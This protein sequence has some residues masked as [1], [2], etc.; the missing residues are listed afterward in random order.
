VKSLLYYQAELVLLRK[1]LHF[2]EFNDHRNG[3]ASQKKFA[4]DLQGLINNVRDKPKD[5]QPNQWQLIEEIRFV[6]D[7][8]NTALIQYSKVSAF[9]DADS[10][11]VL[12]VRD[13]AGKAY[14]N[15]G[16]TGSG[17][18]VWGTLCGELE[19]TTDVEKPFWKLILG[20]FLGLFKTQEDKRPKVP[21][22]FQECLIVPRLGSKPDG[23]TLWVAHSFIPLYHR[24][25][26]RHGEPTWDKL[27]ARLQKYLHPPCLPIA[28]PKPDTQD[29]P[30]LSKGLTLYSS[31]WIMRVTSLMTTI[32]AC[33]LP[34]VA[35]V[36]LS[37]V[38]TMGL[39]LGLIAVFNT[40]F[41]F[42][43]VMISSSS[44]RVDIFTATAAFSAVMV[45]FVQNKLSK[46]S[47]D[48]G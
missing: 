10:L 47:L 32:V 38:H 13:C 27:W 8:Y 34:V 29:T 2:A 42:G 18:T 9:R 26:K 20:L 7:K 39:I 11:N 21:D 4:G 48:R 12:S 36:I 35:I 24:V 44:S 19:G 28:S 43:L 17:S 15:R 5:K 3:D 1:K 46:M 25:W 31:S 30:E 40:I 37:R 45:V 33:L 23:L 14:E 41:A 6:L 16:I 22:E